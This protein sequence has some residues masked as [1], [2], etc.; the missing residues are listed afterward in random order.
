MIWVTWRQQRSLLTTA[1]AVVA[2]L[3][4]IG[5]LERHGIVGALGNGSTSR[6][7]AAFLPAALGVF[8][9]APLLARP[10]ENHTADLMWPQRR[11]WLALTLVPLG[12]ATL[13]VALTVRLVLTGVLEGRFND[14]YRYD[15]V[16]VAAVGFTVFAVALGGFVGAVIGKVEPA[17]LVTLLVYAAVRFVG[18]WV[19]YGDGS[20]DRWYE[21]RWEEL[22]WYLGLS[23]L[24]VAGTFVVVARRGTSS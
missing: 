23:V 18:G 13:T 4:L 21:I 20:W 17:M 7:I 24:L 11:R 5:A 6:T 12:V 9:G 22:G 3:A 14:H 19:R 1:V 15:V 10:L 8:W 16:S 2:G